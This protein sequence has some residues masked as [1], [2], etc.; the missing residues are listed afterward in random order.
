[1]LLTLRQR[2]VFFICIAVIGFL[3]SRFCGGILISK[4]PDSTAAMRIA[5]VV[6]SIFKLIITAIAT[7]MIVTRRSA[8]FLAIDR[9]FDPVQLLLALAGL[10]ASV[11][12]MNMTI[13]LNQSLTLP[14]SLSWLENALKEMEQ[15]AGRSI[16]LL[17]GGN[18]I[19]DLVMNILIIGILAGLGEELFFRGTMLRL[20]TTGRV[21]V[22][23]AIWTVAIIFSALHFQFYGF[24][25]RT[26]LGAYFGYLLYWSRS[27]WI[28]VMIHAS[29][30]ILYVTWQWIYG[31]GSNEPTSIDTVGTDGNP[32]ILSVSFVATAVILLMIARRSDTVRQLSGQS[33][34]L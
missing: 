25:P 8:S 11:P 28:P 31:P 4:F 30:N 23:V 15:N 14:D 26:L 18:T 19:G 29:N 12:L 9:R 20:M 22:H 7:A 32:A 27:L 10:I 13:D 1:M 34:R 21:N 6:Q 3:I 16:E 2:F 24:V 33:D 17:Q 5:A